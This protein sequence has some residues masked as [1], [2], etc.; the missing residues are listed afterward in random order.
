MNWF[1][2]PEMSDRDLHTFMELVHEKCGIKLTASKRSM[3]SAR[4]QKRLRALKLQSFDDYFAYLHS[5]EGNER[6]I[7]PMIDVI[8]TN[9]TEFFREKAHF[10]YLTERWL[11]SLKRPGSG[12]NLRAWSAGCST[13]EEPYTLAMV[14]TE[15][16]EKHHGDFS[17]LATDI[18][19]KVLMQ[20]HQAIYP[21]DVVQS[22]PP[23]LHRKYLLR[24]TKSRQGFFRVIPELRE[25]I[26]FRRLNLMDPSYGITQPL[27]ILFC[28]NVI[29]Y[30]DIET[31]R[32][33]MLKFSQVLKPDG[34][35]FI[36]HSETLH[37]L[38]LPFEKIAPT[39]YKLRGKP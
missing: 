39:I 18:S 38:D 15:F 20:A 22:V 28:R 5:Q 35:L 21:T 32:R 33:I 27:D 17:I 12:L 24:G 16:L 6:E 37:G 31:T 19:T 8:T 1:D 34:L 7:V 23:D 2:A 13:G 25:K 3:I 11:P 36:G 10:D 29:I 14:L 26:I 30:F 9:K 4:L